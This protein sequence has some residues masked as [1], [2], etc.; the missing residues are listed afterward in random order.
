M[1]EH[2]SRLVCNLGA[3]ENREKVARASI[4]IEHAGSSVR[5]VKRS[6]AAGFPTQL[7]NKFPGT[8]APMCVPQLVLVCRSTFSQ[9]ELGEAGFGK[10]RLF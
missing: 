2:R 1:A 8:A 4:G 6:M 3:K 10:A 9:V 7:L 5:L